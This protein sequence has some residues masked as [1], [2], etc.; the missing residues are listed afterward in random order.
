MKASAAMSSEIDLV[1]YT[2]EQRAYSKTFC[3]MVVMLCTEGS[4]A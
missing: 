4:P 1:T 2:P 3:Y